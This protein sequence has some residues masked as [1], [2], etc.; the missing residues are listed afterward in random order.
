MTC[1]QCGSDVAEGTGVCAS[2]GTHLAGYADRADMPAAVPP[3]NATAKPAYQFDV[4]RWTA[5]DRIVGVASLV[6]LISL[7]L[8]WFSVTVTSLDASALGA[9]AGAYTESG[10]TAHGWLWFV[11]I[12]AALILAY[13]ILKAGFAVLPVDLPV[14][15]DLVLFAAAGLNI[16]LIFIAFLLKPGSGI[17]GIGVDWGFGAFLGLIAAIAAV[18]PLALAGR[19][20]RVVSSA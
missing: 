9:S 10:T 3:S 4:A 6:L 16:L 1:S 14:R 13:L 2:C 18:A 5:S 12:I 8:P 19:F 15:H 20:P 7:F 17:P 11:F